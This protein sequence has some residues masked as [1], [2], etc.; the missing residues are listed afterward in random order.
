MRGVRGV[1]T[2]RSF[3]ERLWTVEESLIELYSFTLVSVPTARSFREILE[4]SYR[5]P[6][7]T[8]LNYC[9]NCP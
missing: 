2:A 7:M 8:A 1:S 6:L 4:E 9:V 5:G 3:S